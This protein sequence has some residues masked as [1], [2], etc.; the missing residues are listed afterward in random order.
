MI[1]LV[2]S[3]YLLAIK[4]IFVGCVVLS[5]VVSCCISICSF[6]SGHVMQRPLGLLDNMHDLKPFDKSKQHFSIVHYHTCS[7]R[8]SV[9]SDFSKIAAKKTLSEAI[10][11]HTPL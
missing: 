7:H 4:H 9:L 2:H 11:A 10:S 5:V 6:L 1:V 8:V 3:W